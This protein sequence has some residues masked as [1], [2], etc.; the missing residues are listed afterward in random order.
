M[1]GCPQFSFWIPVDLAKICFSHIVINCTKILTC[2]RH[3]PKFACTCTGCIV[4]N[5]KGKHH[6]NLMSFQNLRMFVFQQKTKKIIIYFFVII[7]NITP[8]G[9]ICKHTYRG[10]YMAAW[11]YEISLQV[12]KNRERVK[13]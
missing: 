10:Y 7:H 6:A 4:N 12:L 8:S 1:R 5:I 11:R 3:H 13:Y 2:S 9:T